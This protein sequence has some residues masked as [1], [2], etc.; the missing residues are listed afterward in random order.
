MAVDDTPASTPIHRPL[1][2]IGIPILRDELARSRRQRVVLGAMGVSACVAVLAI[3]VA[4]GGGGEAPREIERVSDGA[5]PVDIGYVAPVD[6]GPVLVDAGPPP[7][8]I[9]IA[10]ASDGHVRT[11]HLFG[12]ARGFG[13]A[14]TRAGLSGAEAAAVVGALEGVL[15][16]RRCQPDDELTVERDAAGALVRFG[17]RASL[18]HVWEASYDDAGVLR[19]RAVEVP[20]DVTRVG[21]GGVVA[22]S[23][24]A[25]L[26]AVGLGRTLVGI[27]LDVF[28]GRID[29]DRDT[30]SGDAFRV[31]VDEES[32]DGTSLGWGTVHAVEYHSQRRGVLAAYWFAP[33]RDL[34]EFYDET[35]RA[36]HGGWL[37]TPLRFDHISSPFDPRRMHPVLRRVMPHNGIDFAAGSGTPVWAAADGTVTFVGPR[38]PNGNLVSIRHEGGFETFYAHLQRF[39]A[40]LESGREVEQRDVIGYV[41]ST[42]RSTGPH[43]HFGLKRR[44]TWVDP[45]SELNGP[46]RM[47]PVAFQARFREELARLRSELAAVDIP[48]V[49]TA[50]GGAAEAAPEPESPPT[51]G[52]AMD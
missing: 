19:G 25:A 36:L 28:E 30:R 44:G 18:T 4:V 47:L 31:L 7:P 46:G 38:G 41:G 39:A 6:A 34:E 2:S 11:V 26:E 29:F 43:L 24:G 52:E 9:E 51:A 48:A 3:A 12:S 23:L 32:V 13:P 17:Y 16:F 20:V 22:T 21:R 45:A 8:P 27:F 50:A 49:G 40:G 10:E 1:P 42:G 37:R 5:V 14:L 35:G 15:D 33:R